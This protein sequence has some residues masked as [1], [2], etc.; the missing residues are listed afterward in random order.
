[1]KT[2]LDLHINNIHLIEEHL[3]GKKIGLAGRVDCIAEFDGVLSVI[4]FKTSTKEKK[5]MTKEHGMQCA[6][7]ALMY[8]EM[9]NTKI[10]QLVIINTTE[11]STVHI[12]V[13]P[14]EKF[15]EP[16]KEKIKWFNENIMPNI[17]N[18]EVII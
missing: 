10:E 15:I 6:G 8:E 5:Y 18:E 2:E 7:Y 13:K 11:Q 1:M 3:F 17:T 4:D 9:F 14:V 12:H 16:L